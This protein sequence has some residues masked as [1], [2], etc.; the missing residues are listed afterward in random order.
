MYLLALL[1]SLTGLV[2]IDWKL[3][4]AFF[5]DWRRAAKTSAVAVAVF[6]A[7][8]QIGI[9]QHIFF[10]G[11]THYLTGLN[12]APEFPVGELFFLSLLCYSALVLWRVVEEKWPHIS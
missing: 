7:W 2:F 6:C 3:M 5:M 12:L 11:H 8:D 4:L 1:V 9:Q 10:I